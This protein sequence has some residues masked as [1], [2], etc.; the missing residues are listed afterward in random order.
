MNTDAY[1]AD[2]DHFLARLMGP[3]LS[4]FRVAD[5]LHGGTH[6]EDFDET[7]SD[8]ILKR[9]RFM[10]AFFVLAVPAWIPVDYLTLSPENFVGLAIARAILCAA[11]LLLLLFC[12]AR[13][14]P[15]TTA[16]LLTLSMVASVTFYLAAMVL[17]S[18]GTTDAPLAGY[19]AMPIMMVAVTGLYPLTLVF[20]ASLSLLIVASYLGLQLWNGVP[21][22][23][24]TLNTLWV[25]ALIF[26]V[27]LWIQI[28]Q[29]LMLLKLYRESTRDALTGLINRR[30]L[31]K[32]LEFQRQHYLEAG[33]PFSIMMCDIDRF[34]RINDT[35]GHM[36]GDQVLKKAS[37][38]LTE[39]VRRQDVVARFGGEE[40]MVVLPG[41]SLEASKPIAE[42]V[43][44]GFEA[45]GFNTQDGT[46]VPLTLS[47][48]LTPF[49]SD[50]PI[51]DLLERADQL[52]YAAK[53]GGRNQVVAGA[54][55]AETSL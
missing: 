53:Q 42:A 8:Y 36:V 33:T 37:S 5:I 2:R 38:I 15:R 41:L 40:F 3:L 46:Y 32:Q 14:G 13:P 19:T 51:D 50:E 34:K 55:A 35:H 17:M 24:E 54:S 23:S 4:G 31:M 12:L 49:T 11:L 16:V 6:S 45:A 20:G 25:L 44:D 21:L 43:R 26:G 28:G 1:K 48:G 10:L 39:R 30:V 29:L 27:T 52:L 22:S 18:T 9:L 47:I 7:R